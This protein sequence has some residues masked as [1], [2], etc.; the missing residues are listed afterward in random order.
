VKPIRP[1]LW[2][3][4][5][6]G[7]LIAAAGP[8]SADERVD[9][10]I[11]PL[12]IRYAFVEGDDEKFS[13]HHWMKENYAGGIKE[14]TGYLHLPYDI[15]VATEG[16][17]LIDDN[18][19]EGKIR[20]EK[21]NFGFVNFEYVEFR[22]Y[23]DG[24]GGVYYPFTV[25]TSSET[26]KELQLDIGHLKVEAGITFEK[27]P[28]ITFAYERHFKDGAKSR[29]TW[30]TV[31]E[32]AVRRNIGPAWQDIDEI[33]DTFTIG[34]EHTILGFTV[35]GEQK[36][37]FVRSDLSREE[38]FLSAQ[39][40]AADRK[41]RVQNQE[42][43]ADLITTRAGIERW[44][45][46]EKVFFSSGYRFAHLDNR[47][48]ESISEMDQFR[49]P[50]NFANP[51]QIQDA[52]AD[53]DFDSH[54]WVAHLMATPW[55]WLNLSA[56]FKSELLKREGNSTYPSDTTP[57]I[58]DGVINTTEQSVNDNK[59]LRWGE[60]FSVRF[61]AIPRT[62]IYNDVEFEQVRNWL[63]ED[64]TSLRGQSPPNA[65]EIFS[66]E[67]V[68]DVRNGVW[69]LG[70]HF[71][72]WYFLDTT[73]QVRV[74]RNN[75]DYDDKRETLP[76]AS[77]ARS[78]FFDELDIHTKEFSTRV[79]LK[80]VR[81][82]RP[83]FR[84]QYRTDE[85]QTRIENEPERI[86]DTTSHIYTF[87]LTLEPVRDLLVTGS[88]SRQTAATK[89]AANTATVAQV[90]TFNADVDTWLFSAGYVLIQNIVL[91]G[92]LQYSQAENFNDFTST[93]LPLGADFRE[94]NLEAGLRCSPLKFLSVEPKYAFYRYDPDS[95]AEAGEYT[96][97]V[98]WLEFTVAWP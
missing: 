7:S 85:Y 97:H 59:A 56:K 53:N 1:W 48:T 44:F 24:T 27:L 71:S 58:P 60:S 65:N 67:T 69:T 93:G 49:S 87:D 63:S 37:E 32:G 12:P 21:E 8:V 90:P 78:A 81:W 77:T 31:R 70:A 68:T 29:L 6:G 15:A 17:A 20:V 80:P 43:Q 73:N 72:P 86:N 19:F 51:K 22:K 11:T 33:V 57:A 10:S 94:L 62:A 89:T 75:N 84:Y 88:F 96:A 83:A 61:T 54:T 79:T 2:P 40:V 46:N 39:N 41:I 16:H 82:I 76:G 5:I 18:D 74:R 9:F 34:A 3:C 52:R 26:D 42:P 95:H 13:A 92:S 98:I 28:K 45:L 30:T 35:T 14:F 55:S 50:R 25:F 4:L 66:R 47:E 36:W 38:K 64:R 23:Y 91:T